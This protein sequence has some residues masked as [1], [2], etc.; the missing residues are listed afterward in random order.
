MY[1]YLILSSYNHMNFSEVN[2]SLREKKKRLGQR[3]YGSPN[4]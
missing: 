2:L 4:Q 3:V 1:N